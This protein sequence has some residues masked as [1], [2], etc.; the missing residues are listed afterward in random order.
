MKSGPEGLGELKGVEGEIAGS[1]AAW[2]AGRSRREGIR[3]PADP[4]D[5]VPGSGARARERE[6]HGLVSARCWGS[7]SDPRQREEAANDPLHVG[8]A[9]PSS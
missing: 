6:T 7:L 4:E 3:W 8:L 9:H 2:V 5:R 1:V